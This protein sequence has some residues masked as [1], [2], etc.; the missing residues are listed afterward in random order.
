[1]LNF[2]LVEEPQ[3]LLLLLRSEEKEVMGEGSSFQSHA[4][5]QQV[6]AYFNNNI[7]VAVGQGHWRAIP[8]Q[9]T[10]GHFT[11]FSPFVWSEPKSY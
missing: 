3:T 10:M 6:F 1:M 4:V 2:F 8:V 5:Y 11:R 9:L 7:T